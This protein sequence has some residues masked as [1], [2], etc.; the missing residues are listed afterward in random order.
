[1]T[2]HGNERHFKMAA[3]L[4]MFLFLFKSKYRR[5]SSNIVKNVWCLVVISVYVVSVFCYNECTDTTCGGNGKCVNGTCICYDGWQ[6]PSCQFCGGKVRLSEPYGVIIDGLGNYSIDVK[7]SWLIDAGTNSTVRLHLEEFATECGWDHLYIFDGDSVTS[8]LLAVFSGLMYKDGY[9]VRRIPEIVAQSGSALLHF[10]SDVAYNM[11]GFNISYRVNSCP[12]RYSNKNCTGH[13]VC[14]DGVC[15]CDAM[16]QGEAC[17][18]PLCPNNCSYP[19]GICN[20]EKHRCDCVPHFKGDDCS[21]FA[22]KGYWEVI[23]SKGFIPV[24]SAS[25]AAVVFRDSMYILGGESYK[26]GKLA[27]LYDFTGNVWETLHMDIKPFPSGRYGHSAVLF[28]DKIYIYGG[29]KDGGVVTNEL[30]AFDVSSQIWENVTVRS[31]HCNNTGHSSNGSRLC[32]PLQS[33]GHTATVVLTQSKKSHRMIVIFG[34]SPIYG[35]LNTVQEFYFGTR[36]WNIVKTR[37]HP[38]KGGYGHSAVL[39]PHTHKIFVYGGLM[40]D[41]QSNSVLSDKLYSYDPNSQFWTLLRPGP[42]SRYLHTAMFL[43]GGLMLI[44]GGNTHNDTLHSHGAKCY[45]GDMLSY[46]V[47]CDSWQVLSV[48]KN[49]RADVARFGHS[50]VQFQD[51]LYIYGGFDGIMLNDILKYT[52]GK[53]DGAN[54]QSSCLNSKPGIKCVWDRKNQKCIPLSSVPPMLLPEDEIDQR[55]G[56]SIYVRCSERP[57]PDAQRAIKEC[58]QLHHCISCL[59]TS[60]ECQYCA[61]SKTGTCIFSGSCKE[62]HNSNSILSSTDLTFQD[63]YFVQPLMTYDMCEPSDE[64]ICHQLHL[65]RACVTHPRCHWNYAENKCQAIGNLT[66]E[67]SQEPVQCATSCS[68]YTSCGSCTEEECIWC[69]NEGRCV[70]KNAYTT[71]FPYGQCREWTTLKAR[72]RSNKTGKP[73]CGSYKTCNECQSDPECGWCDD[74]SGTGL[75][76]CLPGGNHGNYDISEIE[77]G[78]DLKCSEDRWYFTKCPPC[79]CNGHSTCSQNSSVCNQ[80]CGNLTTGDHCDRCISGYHGNPING[81]HCIPCE[82]SNHGT[83]CNPETGRCFCTTKG[84]IGDKCDKCDVTNHYQGDPANGSCFYDLTIDYQFTFNLSKKDDRHFTQINFKNSPPKSDIDADFSITCSENAKMNITIK[85]VGI[86]EKQI[87]TDYNCTSF[88]SRFGKNE[89]V[90]GVI[91]NVTQTTFYVY[92]YDFQPPLWIVISFSQYPK[93]NIQQFFITFSS[94]FLLLLLIAALFWKLKQK[95]DTFRRRQRLFVELEQMASRPFSQVLV[96]IG[97]KEK[98]IESNQNSENHGD[99]VQ[100]YTT[101][102]KRKKDCPSPIALEPCSGNRAAVLSLLVRLPTSDELYAPSGQS[103]LAI[104]SA[105]V[106]LGNPRK[107]SLDPTT[108]MESKLKGRK[109]FSNQ[110]PDSCI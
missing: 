90:F 91:D 3:E 74:G 32:G 15:T 97:E 39:D 33:A 106:T 64:P 34:H 43:S 85:T 50:A 62:T 26:R 11:T 66:I 22:N 87:L 23:D 75:G 108:K 58:S 37:G 109:S 12:S 57:R 69:Q 61:G 30:W 72:C 77:D 65:C 40:S 100:N 35:Y 103:G 2:S 6:G 42:S 48:P 25:H 79:Q 47:V 82:C 68:E 102:R 99:S 7:C 36:E 17:D 45:S 5:K 73:G 101:L 84:I 29:V 76:K 31:D 78:F 107:V 93:L 67:K 4:Q 81:G 71:S 44:F 86:P 70:D 56:H 19:N 59:T 53:C 41:R 52:P 63:N 96:E 24:G 10:Y 105:L 95:Y 14:I 16:Y 83:L 88:K 60:F 51:S 21:Q 89:H 20:R 13:G 46:D 8:P 49:L 9:S 1:M 54:T 27:Y 94:C 110:H 55:D 80:P 18:Q 38:V 28:G 104:A 92:V 98:V